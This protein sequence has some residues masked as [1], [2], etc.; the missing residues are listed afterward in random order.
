FLVVSFS[1]T[2]RHLY[3]LFG[4][5]TGAQAEF[6]NWLWFGCVQLW[7]NVFFDF[8]T[9]YKV[10]LSSIEATSLWSRTML[11]LFNLEIELIVIVVIV[12]QLQRIQLF[13]LTKER[14]DE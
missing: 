6:L 7:D 14:R 13:R 2:N 8:F 5:F 1:E 4:G 11:F 9:I 12:L 10:H 3:S